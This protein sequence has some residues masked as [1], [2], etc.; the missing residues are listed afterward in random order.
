MMIPGI[1]NTV[2]FIHANDPFEC[3]QYLVG[4]ALVCAANALPFT[5]FIFT[6]FI[7]S[8]HEKSTKL[9]SLMDALYLRLL[10]INF[11]LLKPAMAAVVIINGFGIWNNYAQAVFFLQERSKHNIPQALSVYPAIRG[12]SGTLWQRPQLLP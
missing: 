6:G 12:R 2:P 8:R 3:N 9:P 11:P 5:V 10:L 4:M 1:I 7:R